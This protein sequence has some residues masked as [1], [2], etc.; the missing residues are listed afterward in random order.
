MNNNYFDFKIKLYNFNYYSKSTDCYPITVILYSVIHIYSAVT[1]LF[2][3]ALHFF[4][5]V[6]HFSFNDKIL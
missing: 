1:P 3:S 2:Y 5:I 4:F 6:T